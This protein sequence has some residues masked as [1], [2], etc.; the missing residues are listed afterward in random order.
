M[1]VKWFDTGMFYYVKFICKKMT[2]SKKFLNLPPFRPPYVP[3]LAG[4][5][6]RKP[7]AGIGPEEIA[8][9]TAG[10][11]SWERRTR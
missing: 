6:T 1:Y 9:D 5:G 8:W 4:T 2:V 3:T 7:D 11:A 10:D